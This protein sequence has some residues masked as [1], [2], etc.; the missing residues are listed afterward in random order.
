[1]ILD[2]QKK[3]KHVAW[4]IAIGFIGSFVAFAISFL[5]PP[6]F[7]KDPPQFQEASMIAQEISLALFIFGCTVIGLKL[8]EE[9]K[10]LPAAGFTMMAIAQ[11]V[12]FIL[13][14][15]N[16]ENVENLKEGYN[17]FC[18]MMYLLLPAMIL[19]ALYSQF[20]RWVNAMGIIACLPYVVVYFM[21]MTTK[22]YSTT[23]DQI[24]FVSLILFNITALI[25]GIYVLRNMKK[26]LKEVKEVLIDNVY[27][28]MDIYSVGYAVS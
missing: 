26:E 5:F 22:K 25:W 16:L 8:A 17:T 11:G 18:G 20:P 6:D 27:L 3:T 24:S 19:I 1:M 12:Y 13:Y 10:T 14:F 21:F 4:T 2:E 7:T 28:L 23:L 15:M 9:K